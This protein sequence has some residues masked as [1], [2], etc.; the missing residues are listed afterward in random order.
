LAEDE[1]LSLPGRWVNSHELRCGDVL[2]GQDGQRRVVLKIE[3]EFVSGFLVHNLTIREDHTFAVGADA[4]L[5]HNTAKCGG[6][7]A[8][9]ARGRQVHKDY[10]YGP[11][12]EKEFRLP[13][14]KRADAVNRE[15]GEVIELKPNNVAAVR[16][17]ER[18]VEGYRQELEELFGRPF[19]GTVTT[20]D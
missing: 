5:V 1:G 8:A 13:S 3:Q 4:L 18:Q 9:T 20:Y 2:I 12:F 15:L 10:D 16:R 7:T 6:E 19:N 11:G 14:G 17:G